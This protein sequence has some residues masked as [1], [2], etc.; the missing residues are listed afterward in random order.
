M[1]ST[2]EQSTG[3][4]SYEI[5]KDDSRHYDNIGGCDVHRNLGDKL[6]DGTHEDDVCTHLLYSWMTQ[7]HSCLHYALRRQVGQYSNTADLLSRL[8]HPMIFTVRNQTVRSLLIY[9]R[10]C[11]RSRLSCRL[12][13]RPPSDREDLLPYKR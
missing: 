9:A 6:S 8:Q 11:V 10:R 1:C 5:T 4:A 3:C 2:T 13:A 7:T 12:P